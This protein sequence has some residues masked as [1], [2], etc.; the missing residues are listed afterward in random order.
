LCGEY[1]ERKTSRSDWDAELGLNGDMEK[2]RKGAGQD[3]FSDPPFFSCLPVHY[4][5]APPL[6]GV[7][8]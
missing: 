6:N 2:K 3:D 5:M 4:P 8:W 7:L 1:G